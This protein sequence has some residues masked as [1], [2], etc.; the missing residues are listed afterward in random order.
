MSVMSAAV[1]YDC[2]VV[3]VKPHHPIHYCWRSTRA[4]PS[5]TQ[6]LQWRLRLWLYN[7]TQLLAF[8][9]LTKSEKSVPDLE[10]GGQMC[11]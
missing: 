2:G 5:S 6:P 1:G 10:K 3:L 4:I 8:S 11:T 9:I 7:R